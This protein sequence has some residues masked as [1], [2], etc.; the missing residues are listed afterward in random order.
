MSPVGDAG[1]FQWEDNKQLPPRVKYMATHA[2]AI[3]PKWA[4]V[5]L[6]GIS[7]GRGHPK[8]MLHTHRGDRQIQLDRH[9]LSRTVAFIWTR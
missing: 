1:S 3:I 8:Q 5:L 6:L 7:L 4:S 2:W 9:V